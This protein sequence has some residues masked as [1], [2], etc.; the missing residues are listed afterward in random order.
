M[1]RHLSTSPSKVNVPVNVTVDRHLS[2]LPSE[3]NIAGMLGK[4]ADWLIG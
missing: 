1:D 3:I 2:T 4:L